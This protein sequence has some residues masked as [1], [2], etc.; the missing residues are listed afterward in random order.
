MRSNKTHIFRYQHSLVSASV[1]LYSRVSSC[2]YISFSF[3]FL[4]P[5]SLTARTLDTFH[6]L[7]SFSRILLD[8]IAYYLVAISRV[9]LLL[10]RYILCKNSSRFCPY[11][12][13]TPRTISSWSNFSLYIRVYTV[14]IFYLP[15][16]CVCGDIFASLFQIDCISFR[17]TRNM[18]NKTDW[19]MI[20]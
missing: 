12:C 11:F 2:V 14:T 1:G 8:K 6:K 20:C 17:L 4:F 13:L 5:R 19:L 7:S 15:Q 16:S 9:D 10:L 18:E 3:S